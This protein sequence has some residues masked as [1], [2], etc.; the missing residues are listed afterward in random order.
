MQRKFIFKDKNSEILLPVTPPSFTMTQGINIETINIHT[1]GDVNIAGYGTLANLKI[2]CLF[3]AQSYPFALENQDPYVYVDYFIKWCDERE[4]LRFIV[5]DTSVNIAV[6]VESITYS[7]KDGTNDVYATIILREYREL[8]AVRAEKA[9]SGNKTRVAGV[10]TSL[11]S[12]Y[13][14]KKGDTLSSICRKFY[15]DASLYPKLAAANNIKNP[16]LIYA[17]HTLKI[18]DKSQL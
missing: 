16:N 4:V 5:S 12:S 6:L 14:I 18:L 3:P 17:G 10:S 13:T 7:E 1:L 9:G 11:A 2:D 8:S 15:G